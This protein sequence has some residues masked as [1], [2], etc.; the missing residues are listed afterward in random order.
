MLN[1][2]ITVNLEFIQGMVH[3]QK[4][5][6]CPKPSVSQAVI[7]GESDCHESAAGIE[8]IPTISSQNVQKWI[9]IT[10]TIVDMDQ[11]QPPLHT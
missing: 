11:V 2:L 3:T 10:W 7:A 4:T 6:F 1:Y 5:P 9:L 8:R